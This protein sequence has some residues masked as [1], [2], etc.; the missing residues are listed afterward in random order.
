ME[1]VPEHIAVGVRNVMNG[2][3]VAQAS[4]A[5]RSQERYQQLERQL[6][7]LTD[8]FQERHMGGPKRK[9]SE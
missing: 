4:E 9:K 7:E 3:A 1:D 5:D 2:L 6:L 8:L